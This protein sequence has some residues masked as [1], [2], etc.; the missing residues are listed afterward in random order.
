MKDLSRREF[1]SMS[2]ALGAIALSA[3]RKLMAQP[4]TLEVEL[5]IDSAT[6]LGKVPLDY[7]GLSYESG[8]LAYPDFFSPR[9]T[10]L[11]QMFRTLSPSGVLR[12]GGNLSEFTLWSETEPATPPEAG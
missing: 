2:A 8:Q 3:P 10:T 9:N 12:L 11:I 4:S 7:M 6:S 1:C 5:K